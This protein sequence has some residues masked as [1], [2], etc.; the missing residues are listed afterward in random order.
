MAHNPE[1]GEASQEEENFVKN[2]LGICIFV[3]G[4]LSV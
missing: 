4:D 2:A 3:T 1:E